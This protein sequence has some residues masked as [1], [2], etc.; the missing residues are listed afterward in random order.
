MRRVRGAAPRAEVGSVATPVYCPI[1]GGQPGVFTNLYINWQL[2]NECTDYTASVPLEY[3]TEWSDPGLRSATA[4]YCQ[5][6]V[7][8]GQTYAQLEGEINTALSS[9]IVAEW[10]HYSVALSPVCTCTRPGQSSC[11]GCNGP[12]S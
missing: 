1:V 3:G 5:W 12:K 6:L 8:P 9:R 2:A 4:T 10:P 7:P 11:V